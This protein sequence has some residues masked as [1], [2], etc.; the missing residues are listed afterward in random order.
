MNRCYRAVSPC[1][2]HV[3]LWL[4]PQAT[5]ASSRAPSLPRLGCR[6]NGSNCERERLSREPTAE[7]RW[8]A[9]PTYPAHLVTTLLSLGVPLSH[10]GLPLAMGSAVSLSP[11]PGSLSM[12]MFCAEGVGA[13][14]RQCLC[15]L[16]QRCQGAAW[17]RTDPG[18]FRSCAEGGSWRGAWAAFPRAPE[19]PQLGAPCLAMDGGAWVPK[20]KGVDGRTGPHLSHSPWHQRALGKGERRWDHL[21]FST[22]M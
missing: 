16:E 20:G 18:A 14:G 15:C 2:L 4:R 13:L 5:E 6:G 3:A 22:S 11:E 21:G 17:A 9:S 7:S 12:E 10:L 8:L 19:P 1:W